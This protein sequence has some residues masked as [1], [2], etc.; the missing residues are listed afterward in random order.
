MQSEEM[1]SRVS[2]QARR[3]CNAKSL[4]TQ[5]PES[6]LR[7]VVMN[8][9]TIPAAPRTGTPR[10]RFVVQK[11]WARSLHYDFR[12]EIGTAL[13][14]WAVPKGPSK[15]P[16]VKRVAVHVEDHPLDYLLV[17][18][19]LPEG[20]YGAGEVIVWDFGEYSMVGPEGSD[21]AAALSDGI[22]RFALYGTKLRG[23]WSIVRTRMGSGTR[24]NWL[25]Q[26]IQDE[27]AEE[28]YDP[29]TQP[30]SALSGKVPRRQR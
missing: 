22:M 16:K 29:E 14:S 28:G 3:R 21:A 18:E 1:R 15:D 7:A 13:V 5:K 2:A 20:Q 10:L 4:V 23:G 17:E 6:P 12:L 24:E 25:L 19:T 11:H 26:K 9:T 8:D 30:P 27:F